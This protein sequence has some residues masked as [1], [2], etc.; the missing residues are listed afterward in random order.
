MRSRRAA[1]PIPEP[2]R[3][4]NGPARPLSCRLPKLTRWSH[5]PMASHADAGVPHGQCDHWD[6]SRPERGPPRDR[7]SVVRVSG[8]AQSDPHPRAAAGPA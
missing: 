8:R 2:T 4:A 1:V 6:H 5:D 7:G 3:S